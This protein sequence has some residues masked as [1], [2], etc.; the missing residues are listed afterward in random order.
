MTPLAS[1]RRL[2]PCL[3]LLGLS[4]SGA[5]CESGG[6]EPL[7]I[8]AAGDAGDGGSGG[9]AGD[10]GDGGGDLDLGGIGDAGEDVSAEDPWPD[11]GAFPPETGPGGPTR[12]FTED[13]LFQNCAFLDGGEGDVFDH[14]N[15]VVM[16]DGYLLMPWA[17][18]SGGG[19]LTLWEFTDPCAPVRV[20]YGYSARMRETHSIG[21]SPVGGRWAVTDGMRALPEAEVEEKLKLFE[22]GLLFWDVSD[23]TA[24]A[25]VVHMDLPGFHYPDAYARVTLAVSWQAPWVYASGAD[26]GVYVVDATDPASPVLVR[27]FAFEPVFRA[28]QIHAIGNL[29]VVTGAEEPRTVLLDISDPA[30]P[31]P[32]PGGDFAQHDRDGIP[33]ETYF[34]NVAGGFLYYARKQGG[35]GVMVFDVRDPT[36][37][38]F[39]KDVFSLGNGGYVFVKDEL[40]FVGESSFATMYDLTALADFEPAATFHLKGDLDTVTPIGNVAVLSCDDKADT[41]QATAVAPFALE[42]DTK[43]PRVTWVQPPDGAVAQALST[44]IGFTT[45]EMVSVQSAWEGS[46]RL[47]AEGVP[48]AKGGL[49]PRGGEIPSAAR[50]RGRVEG[51]V[52]AQENVVNFWPKEP[53]A[54]GTTYVLEVP[55]GGLRDYNGNAIEE[56]FTSTFTTVGE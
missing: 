2:A 47:R 48:P 25:E 22:G 36:K 56:P 38:T 28:G 24:P 17:P 41:D 45:S 20:G 10:G 27:Q 18:E 3:V 37:P 30:D 26:N 34:S 43:P 16:Y 50:E 14:H 35:G 33:R 6:G 21:F 9:A 23:S 11:P 54:P 52:S 39:S 40:A 42:P 8:A 32:I 31:Q 46:V 44:R 13:E 29:L 15:L 4:A 53:L 55:A 19:G 7:E 49:P 1:T 51:W 12:T 5:A